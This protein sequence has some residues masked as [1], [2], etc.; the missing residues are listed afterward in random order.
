MLCYYLDGILAP[1]RMSLHQTSRCR[2]TTKQL[3][4]S[5]DLSIAGCW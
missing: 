4:Y 1:M 3:S 5:H 2:T